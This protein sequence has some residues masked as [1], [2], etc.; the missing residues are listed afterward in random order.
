MARRPRFP[1]PNA[2]TKPTA[3]EAAAASHASLTSVVLAVLA[4]M[5]FWIAATGVRA[6]HHALTVL[7]AGCGFHVL[8]LALVPRVLSE[9]MSLRSLWD[10]E[11]VASATALALFALGVLG[12]IW[13]AAEWLLQL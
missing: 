12:C 11:P 1:A 2:Q 4:S 6:G 3:T 5:L 7:D 9:H 10:V 13:A 8:A